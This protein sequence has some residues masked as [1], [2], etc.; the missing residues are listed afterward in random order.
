MPAAWAAAIGGVASLAG[1]IMG[2]N[3]SKDAAQ[4]QADASKYAANLQQQRYQETAGN[5][6]PYRQ[7]GTQSL[8]QLQGIMG[9]GPGGLQAVQGMVNADPSYQF[10]LSQGQQAIDKAAAAR[11]N[12]YAPQTLQDIGKYSQGVASNEYNQIWQRLFNMAGGGQN[13]AVQQGGFGL[14][15]ATNQGNAMMQGANASAAGTIGAANAWQTALAGIGGAAQYYMMDRNPN[16][17]ADYL[18]PAYDTGGTPAV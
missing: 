2:A 10:N 12:F 6:A 11:G 8:A 7:A 17:V 5:L 3:A 16:A 1:G 18:G 15:A 14:S 4:Q 9:Q 13:A